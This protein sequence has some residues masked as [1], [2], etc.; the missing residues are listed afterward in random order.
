MNGSASMTWR[1]LRSSND[2]RSQNEIS[3]AANG[4][5]DRFS[6]SAVAAP[7]R[8]EIASPARMS[9]SNPGAAAGDGEQREHGNKSH[10]DSGG[11]Q[12]IGSARRPSR[13]RSSAPRR[14][15][16]IAA[17]R[18]K[19]AT[20]VDCAGAPARRHPDRPNIAPIAQC[21][22]RTRQT[23]FADDGLMDVAAAAGQRIE[24]RQR[25][26]PHRAGA[27]RCERQRNHD[28]DEDH[29]RDVASSRWRRCHH[30]AFK[31]A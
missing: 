14:T 25:R 12:C 19:T 21:E 8:L 7:A 31:P 9:N 2:P 20:P 27:E 22:D 1:K 17:R 26:H 30:L 16:R 6:T 28:R 13:A 4:F 24:Y 5:G 11:R 3:S 23:D 18:T 29:R 10:R 15:R